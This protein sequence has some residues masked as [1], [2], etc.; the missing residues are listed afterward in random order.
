VLGTMYRISLVPFSLCGQSLEEEERKKS[1]DW[2][3]EVLCVCV[4]LCV[5]VFWLGGETAQV[6]ESVVQWVKYGNRKKRS[7][8]EISLSK[9]V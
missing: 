6:D 1:R 8:R 2:P 7:W 3:H 9:N 4:C 5:C